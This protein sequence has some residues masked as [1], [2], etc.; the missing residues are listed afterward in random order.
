MIEVQDLFLDLVFLA[1]GMHA[2]I[3]Q[4]CKV[5]PIVQMPLQGHI[6]LSKDEF[7]EVFDHLLCLELKI[8]VIID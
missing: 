7:V 5:R 8:I 6:F 4:V 2:F 1:I 3:A